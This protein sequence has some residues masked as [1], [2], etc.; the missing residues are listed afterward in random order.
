M[1]KPK[2]IRGTILAKFTEA[3][4]AASRAAA[5][6]LDEAKPGDERQAAAKEMEQALDR[7]TELAAVVA[8]IQTSEAMPNDLSPE[9][10]AILPRCRVGNIVNAAISGSAIPASAPEAELGAELGVEV[11]GAAGPTIP[12]HMLARGRDDVRAQDVASS[13]TFDADTTG[14]VRRAP[15]INRVFQ[16]SIA[17]FLG[18]R[19]AD[20]AGAESYLTISSGPAAAQKSPGAAVAAAA[21]ALDS[22]LLVPKRLAS[23]VV[24]RV[25]DAERLGGDAWEMACQR[26]LVMG[27]QSQIDTQIVQGSGV[28]PQVDGLLAELADPST[29][30][31]VETFATYAKSLYDSIDGA[32][33]AMTS[34]IRMLV[35]IK[36]YAHMGSLIISNTSMTTA[37]KMQM[38]SGGLRA[39]KHL[40]DA[41]SNVEQSIQYFTGASDAGPPMVAAF[42]GGGGV[43]LVKDVVT[44]SAAGEI[45][46]TAQILWDA[47]PTQL[48]CYK[49]LQ[50]KTA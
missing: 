24:L 17:N 47:A 38:L 8:D 35:G 46:V 25:E 28:A 16:K 11:N 31:A 13:V 21:V 37:E 19:M 44:K 7:Q 27:V 5:I 3:K 26:D 14:P 41:V 6:M 34:D 20:A 12:W 2:T 42:F 1:A 43:T 15:I 39:T 33:A 23:R 36:T 45:A 22:K 32:Y 40:P 4:N 50:F 10:A 49:Q 29:R 48:G 30:S 9:V 18:V